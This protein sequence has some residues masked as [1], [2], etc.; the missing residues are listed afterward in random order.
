MQKSKLAQQN[1]S[2]GAMNPWLKAGVLLLASNLAVGANMYGVYLFGKNSWLSW[3]LI[4]GP[5]LAITS[6]ICRDQYS[7]TFAFSTWLAIAHGLAHVIFPFLDE[8]LGVVKSVSVW[9]DQTLHLGQAILFATILRGEKSNYFRAGALLFILAN[10]VNVIAGYLCW[11]KACHEV[12]VWLSLA[13]ALASGLHFATGALFQ[14]PN[15]V[16]R[17]GFLLQGCSSIIT[18][19]LFKASDDMLMLFARCRFFELYFIAPHY[20]GYF[21]SRYQS[22]GHGHRLLREICELIG[23]FP[24][25]AGQTYKSKPKEWIEG[26]NTMASKSFMV[27]FSKQA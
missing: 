27:D 7:F 17:R 25:K 8:H 5:I 23:V 4:Y 3:L 6:V 26:F 18:F 14:Q 15:N 19:F 12:Y 20:I 21:V 9:E 24:G 1:I 22:N 2:S 11:G 16:T 10:V 13:P